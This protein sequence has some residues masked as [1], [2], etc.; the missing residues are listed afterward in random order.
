MRILRKAGFITLIPERLPRMLCRFFLQF[1]RKL[2]LVHYYVKFI[3][4]STCL[5]EE[6]KKVKQVQPLKNLI[7]LIIQFKCIE[8]KE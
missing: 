7:A 8:W 5:L 2:S 6:H 1:I 4:S 3:A